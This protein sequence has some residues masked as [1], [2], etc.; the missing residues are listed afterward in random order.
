MWLRERCYVVKT[1]DD[2][3]RG[4]ADYFS[5]ICYSLRLGIGS[6]KTTLSAVMH[7]APDFPPFPLATRC[8]V[9]FDRLRL[10]SEGEGFSEEVWGLLMRDL[11]QRGLREEMTILA[12]SVDTYARGMDWAGVRVSDVSIARVGDSQRVSVRFGVRDRGEEAKTGIDQGVVIRRPWVAKL[13]CQVLEQRRAMG[14]SKRLFRTSRNAFS[15]AWYASLSNCDC[16]WI[17]PPHATRHAGATIDCLCNNLSLDS[18][19]LRGRW[20]CVESVRRYSKP[21]VLVQCN[22]KFDD[23]V[24]E[25]GRKFLELMNDI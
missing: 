13:V 18:I 20:R 11:F 23:S 21:F 25:Q 16:S 6:A 2:L 9:A 24:L 1:H 14:A 17:G 15:A 3:D 12:F 8:L 4:L 10:G 22:A 19:K 7:I 5:Y